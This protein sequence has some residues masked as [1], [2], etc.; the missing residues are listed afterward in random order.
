[1]IDIANQVKISHAII[2]ID[3]SNYSNRIAYLIS[4]I[5]CKYFGLMESYI[6]T[7]FS[8]FQNMQICLLVAYGLSN[9]FYTGLISKLF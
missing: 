9:N 8:I 3:A 5:T 4:A 2:S 7:F 1:M 6:T